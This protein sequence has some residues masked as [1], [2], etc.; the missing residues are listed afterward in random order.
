MSVKP[1][2]GRGTLFTDKVPLN[3]TESVRPPLEVLLKIYYF[4]RPELLKTSP[5]FFFFFTNNRGVHKDVL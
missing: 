4:H 2:E 3:S 5:I 1:S